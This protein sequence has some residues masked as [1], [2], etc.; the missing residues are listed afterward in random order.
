MSFILK[1]DRL[2][3]LLLLLVALR[4]VSHSQIIELKGGDSTMFGAGGGN[5]ILHFPHS[6]ETFGAGIVDGQF[7]FGVSSSFDWQKW[8]VTA[9]DDYLSLTAGTGLV[10][11]IRGL[12]A[13]RRWKKQKLTLFTGA[14]GQ[15]YSFPYFLATSVRHFGTGMFYQ[16]KLPHGLDFSMMG[17]FVGSQR[18]AVG[19]LHYLWKGLDAAGTAGLLQSHPFGNGRVSYKPIQAL[20]FF[21]TRQDYFFDLR[22][23]STAGT[24]SSLVQA[25]TTISSVGGSATLRGLSLSA[26]ALT[27][28]AG[29]NQIS[30]QT[31]G[32][33]VHPGPLAITTSYYRSPHSGFIASSFTERLSRRWSVSEFLTYSQGRWS[34][35]YG[36]SFTSNRLTAS[37]GY[38]TDFVPYSLGGSPFQQTI[39]VSVSWQLPHS[40]TVTLATN[41]LPNGA[42]RWSTYGNSYVQ[43]P[44]QSGDA[45]AGMAHASQSRLGAKFIVRGI[46]R[47]PAGR[48]V[49]GAAVLVGKEMV[50]TDFDGTFFVRFRKAKTVPVKVV[51]DDFRAPGN[52]RVIGAPDLVTPEPIDKETAINIEV[53]RVM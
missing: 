1:N 45:V 24:G 13:E 30:G 40:T 29:T 23:A 46:V 22:Q 42:V 35:N 28:S 38:L 21:A 12:T 53:S 9:G 37:V 17:V 32:G 5:A 25:A 20:S 26:S 3:L 31:F 19:S 36:G 15:I 27:G 10:V 34:V 48:P 39:S 51:P 33:S 2:F 16:N 47:D 4:G 6:T 41:T 50:F 11:P 43:G 52:W 7:H 8:N 18:T 49:A 14:A 44:L